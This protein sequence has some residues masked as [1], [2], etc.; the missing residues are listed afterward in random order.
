MFM[1]GTTLIL[2]GSLIAVAIFTV[3]FYLGFATGKYVQAS[4]VQAQLE[5]MSEQ[6][7][8]IRSGLKILNEELVQLLIEDK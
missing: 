6:V 4:T 3:I 7:S 2:V 1:Q 5:S 8:T